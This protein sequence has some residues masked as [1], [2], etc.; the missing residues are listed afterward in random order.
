MLTAP[1]GR[2]SRD[3]WERVSSD[4]RTSPPNPS[5]ERAPRP[6][7]ARPSR[8]SKV[9][10]A[11]APRPAKTS[12]PRAGSAASASSRGLVAKGRVRL[13]AHPVQGTR[14][15]STPQPACV[16]ARRLTRVRSSVSSA[17]RSRVNAAVAPGSSVRPIAVPRLIRRRDCRSLAIRSR[18]FVVTPSCPRALPGVR[19][20]R[21]GTSSSVRIR[22]RPYARTPSLA[23]ATRSGCPLTASARALPIPPARWSARTS[24][25]LRRTMRDS[26]S[27][28]VRRAFV[29][30]PSCRRAVP[31][32]RV[33]QDV[34]P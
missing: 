16:R 20:V 17:I 18:A 30:I 27:P 5:S 19:R 26:H 7:A 8:A 31:T 25:V 28:A 14:W 4:G 15:S 12:S 10:V 13:G 33:E 2:S 22:T 34:T 6:S 32:V 3:C 1:A 29:V 11:R 21:Q 24:A 23:R 9:P